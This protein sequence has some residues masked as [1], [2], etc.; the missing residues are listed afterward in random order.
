[1][2]IDVKSNTIANA[3]GNGINDDTDALEEIFNFVTQ[4]GESSTFD[5]RDVIYFPPGR[6]RIS[7][8]LQLRDGWGTRLIGSGSIKGSL[9]II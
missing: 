4:F 3:V 5:E 9:L 1:M 7:R 6:Y 2:W 8:T